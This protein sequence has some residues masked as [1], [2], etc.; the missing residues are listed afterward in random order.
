M[1][2]DRALKDRVIHL[3]AQDVQKINLLAF[4][5]PR[6]A[7]TVVGDF[8]EL[9][10]RV[11][12]LQNVVELGGLLPRLVVLEGTAFDQAAVKR[13]R[14]LLVLRGEVVHPQRLLKLLKHGQ[15]FA[16]RVQ[17]FPLTPGKAACAVPRVDDIV[18]VL[19]R[20]GRKA[21]QF[22]GFFFQHVAY[23]VVFVQ[24]LHDQNHPARAFVVE[25][26]A[27]RAAEPLVGGFALRVGERFRRLLWIVDDD[28]VRPP[29]GCN[30]ADRGRHAIAAGR[31]LELRDAVFIVR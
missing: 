20:N 25:P 7:D 12:G 19:F 14:V 31:S 2:D 10:R 5:T 15:G 3:A 11:P 22:P 13:R 16:C 21:H 4:Y 8:A 26:A 28:D 18:L 30:A 6:C 1:I 17:R 24:A 23:Q 29:P 9:V 27:Q